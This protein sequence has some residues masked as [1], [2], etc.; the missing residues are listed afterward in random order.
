M[1]KILTQQSHPK[2]PDHH[3][4]GIILD[5]FRDIVFG[6]ED[7]MVST[8][9]VVTGIALASHDHFTVLL[10][11]VVVIAVESLS[12]GV[13]SY[14]SNKAERDV[15]RRKLTEERI[16]TEEF[17]EQE[18]QELT[19]FYIKDGWPKKFA[20]EMT[21]V[22]H[23]DKELF[24]KEMAYHELGIVV[25]K[26]VNPTKNGIFMFFAYILGGIIPVVPYFI[27][28][29]DQAVTISVVLSLVSLFS[30][31]TLIGR[32]TKRLWWK[33]GLELLLLAGIAGLVGY[34]AGQVFNR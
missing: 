3:K 5:S 27:W 31:G 30:L 23:Q 16:E 21:S 24:L 1:T 26:P 29:I 12:M 17:P 11:G 20:Q 2:F 33:A 15:S 13:G 4:K 19:E 6:V 25:N 7:G 22:A 14:I 10:S 18:K 8:F 28:E 34:I 32:H 9:G